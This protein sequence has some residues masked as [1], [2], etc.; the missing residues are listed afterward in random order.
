M[1]YLIGGNGFVGSAFARLLKA[2]KLKHQIITRENADNFKGT[3]CSLLINANGNSKKYMADREPLAE[4]EASVLSVARSLEWYKA[5][6]YVLLSSGDVYPGPWSTAATRESRVID[7]AKLSRYG[8]HKY[9]AEQLVRG[10]HPNHLIIRMSGFVGPGLAKNA[11]YDMMTGG[12]LW[13]SL[14]SRLQFMHTNDAARIVL[15]LA[16]NET[17][18]NETVNLGGI[19]KVSLRQAYVWAK[20]ASKLKKDAKTVTYELSLEKL[21]R[22]YP[23]VLPES[24][25]AVKAFLMDKDKA[26]G[27]G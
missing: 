22:L 1:I 6:R 17:I 16:R 14:N 21:K 23:G 27:Q 15:N 11:I 24:A 2:N 19:G 9:L 4:F 10:A 13:L 25:R 18:R 3:R 12:D 5:E 20:S 8:L 26:S 7:P